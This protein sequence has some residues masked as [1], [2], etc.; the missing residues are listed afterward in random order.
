MRVRQVVMVT[1]AAA[2]ALAGGGRSEAAS[3]GTDRPP[4]P[5]YGKPFLKTGGAS[6]GG[7]MDLEF[8]ANGDGSTFDQH[9]FV[10][11]IYAG[12]SDRVHV[13]SEIEFEHG[14]FVTGEDEETDGEIKLE[15]AQVDFTV[16]EPLVFRA[17][18]VLSPL[19]RLN[20]L[21]DSPM[22]DLTERPLVDRYVIPT[23]LSESGIGAYGTLYPSE[24]W[25]VDYQAYLV[26]GFN[27][28]AV[29]MEPGPD[30]AMRPV[31]DLREGRGSTAED[32]N[33]ARSFTGRLGVSPRLGTEVGV[34]VHTG[35]YDDAGDHRLTLAAVDARFA[36]GPVELLG[37]GALARTS[38]LGTEGAGE[39]AR[40]A[41][42]YAEGRVHFLAGAIPSLPRSVFTG[43]V[44][45][46]YV[47][48]DR[49]VDGGDLERLTLG[50]N[51][52]PTEETVIK[53]DLLFD[54]SRAV[55]VSDWGDTG[56]AYRFSVATYF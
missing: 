32:N 54:R 43:A 11:F 53:N 35:K 25:V 5:A 34:S 7:Y 44:R 46:G 47:D 21:H 30:D 52:R 27:A 3:A 23:T 36:G 41:G 51:F 40:A 12:V 17:G 26:N 49:N 16:A 50:V 19:G 8:K 24:T 38:E 31:L 39:R 45:V 55:F 33:N 22:L 42:F 14:G 28:H 15:F 10:P 2:A 4:S 13:S 29:E 37:E 6:L 9:R 1:I 56:T 18:I 20:E 48:R